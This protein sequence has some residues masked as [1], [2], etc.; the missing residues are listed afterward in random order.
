MKLRSGGILLAGVSLVV[1][2]AVVL[3]FLAVGT[4][5][6]ERRR[7]LDRKRV[8]SLRE[9]AQVILTDSRDGR[10]H[11]DLPAALDAAT[12]PGYVGARYVDPVTRKP[13]GFRKLGSDRFELCATFDT[14]RKESDLESWEAGWSHAAGPACFEFRLGGNM[15]PRHRAGP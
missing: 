4:P 10:I 6:E 5:R 12:I 7:D 3:G 9:L 14:E 2:V 8:E 13:F 15:A 1:G 11:R